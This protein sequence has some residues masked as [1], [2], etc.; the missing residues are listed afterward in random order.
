M[1][2][3]WLNR[4]TALFC[5]TSMGRRPPCSDPRVGLRSAYHISPRTALT[6]SPLVPARGHSHPCLPQPTPDLP[7][8]IR[9]RVGQGCFRP[10]LEFGDDANDTS[11]MR[12]SLPP[13]AL[14]SP[15]IAQ[16]HVR[17][18]VVATFRLSFAGFVRR[19]T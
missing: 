1:T 11:G 2:T 14:P 13:V 7:Q 8:R 6:G 5:T 18:V 9:R 10:L 19:E 15:A 16:G 12:H 3:V 4:L 17:F